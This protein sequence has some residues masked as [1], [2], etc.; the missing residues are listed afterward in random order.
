[1]KNFNGDFNYDYSECLVFINKIGKNGAPDYIVYANDTACSKLG[2]TKDEMTSIDTVN[3][4][5]PIYEANLKDELSKLFGGATVSYAML[6]FTKFNKVI[7]TNVEVSLCEFYG[8]MAVLSIAREIN[9]KDF[10][11]N[12]VI[13]FNNE[14]NSKMMQIKETKEQLFQHEKLAVIG[15]MAAGV[16][17]EINNPLGYISSNVETGQKYFYKIKKILDSYDSLISKLSSLSPHELNDEIKKIIDLKNQSNIDFIMND[18]VE[19]NKDIESGLK[20]IS[21]IV[22]NLKIFSRVDTSLE[23]EEY[24]LNKGIKETLNMARNE[25]KYNAN[26]VENLGNIPIIMASGNRINEVLLN[27]ILN[28]C[29]AIKNKKSEENG[30]IIISTSIEDN[31]VVCQ[32]EDNG[33][34]IESENLTRIFDPFFT[35]KPVGSGTGLGLSISYDIVVNKHNG[36]IYTESK[37]GKGTKTTIKLPALNNERNTDN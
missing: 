28:S 29:Y 14:L 34:G 12:I 10:T 19:L 32:I 24:D 22:N 27:I 5:M 25:I 30:L 18:I 13:K 15:Q 26:V 16:A 36:K 20:R 31:Y 23:F 7:L 2:Y 6:F 3:I 4:G 8:N 9:D 17:H 33:I 35:T 11:R 21:E 1:M 37:L